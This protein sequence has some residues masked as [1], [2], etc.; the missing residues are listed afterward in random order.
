MEGRGEKGRRE[1]RE[2]R[3]RGREGPHELGGPRAPKHVK[4]ALLIINKHFNFCC[5]KALA[6]TTLDR[7]CAVFLYIIFVSL[8]H[9]WL[10]RAVAFVLSPI[11]VL[12]EKWA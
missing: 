1:G 11:H 7:Q 6:Y 2:G 5:F 8:M 9:F 10:R 4:T 3:E 12:L